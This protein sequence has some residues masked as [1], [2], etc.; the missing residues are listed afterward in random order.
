MENKVQI[1]SPV[2]Q[3]LR[4]PDF[5]SLSPWRHFLPSRIPHYR[6]TDLFI[7][8]WT[9]L[10]LPSPSLH[11]S[12]LHHLEINFPLVSVIW[13][14]YSYTRPFSRKS[15]QMPADPVFSPFSKLWPGMPFYYSELPFITSYLLLS[16]VLSIHLDYSSTLPRGHI[17]FGAI[18]SLEAPVETE[19]FL[20]SLIGL[21]IWRQ[22]R[23]NNRISQ[24]PWNQIKSPKMWT[25]NKVM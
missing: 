12:H 23:R 22:V 3:G 7:T 13:E 2:I 17:L 1:S 19:E 16:L 24:I 4:P 11:I 15:T 6:Q 14:S 21:Y 9:S 10:L 5:S 25:E 20:G 18:P 8:S